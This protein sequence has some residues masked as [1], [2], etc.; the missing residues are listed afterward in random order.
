M[1]FADVSPLAFH[2]PR[3]CGRGEIMHAKRFGVLVIA[4]AGLGFAAPLSAATIV[5]DWT[6]SNTGYSGSGYSGTP[7]DSVGGHDFQ[8]PYGGGPTAAGST[9][10]PSSTSSHFA[11]GGF[12][13]TATGT[14]T[15]PTNN[16]SV[17][18][19]AL[20]STADGLQQGDLF[21][22]QG[23][24]TGELQIGEDAAGNW[25]AYI[26]SS[27]SNNTGTLIGSVPVTLDA[28]QDIVVT[29][30]GNVYALSVNGVS[31][32]SGVTSSTSFVGFGAIH[33]AVAPGGGGPNYVGAV[34]DVTISSGVTPEPASLGLCAL[35]SLG[36]LAR[37]RRA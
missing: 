4:V 34:S 7:V 2:F 25:V 28:G 9:G 11:T 35:A 16:F 33:V 19:H 36:L 27:G 20:V 23:G 6:L 37:R 18:M 24:T 17:E 21:S 14:T 22:S 13:S 3:D 31:G 10:G 15:L 29:D 30:I 26:D 8:T 12:Y 5:A 32:G 1:Q